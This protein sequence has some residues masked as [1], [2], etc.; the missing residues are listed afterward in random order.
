I[1]TSKA[2]RA[3][4]SRSAAPAPVDRPTARAVGIAAGSD[5]VPAAVHQ[6]LNTPS[7]AG[8]QPAT[9]PEGSDLVNCRTLPVLQGISAGRHVEVCQVDHVKVIEKHVIVNNFGGTGRL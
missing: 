3:D 8:D 5:A 1:E 6:T 9:I 4:G 7:V 2:I